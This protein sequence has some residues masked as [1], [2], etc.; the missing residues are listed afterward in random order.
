MGSEKAFRRTGRRHDLIA[1]GIADPREEELPAVGLLEVED[2]ETGRH[3]LLDTLSRQ[4]RQAFAAAAR[5][6]RQ[7]LQQLARSARVDLIE[8][9]TDGGH[10]DALIRFFRMR[11]RRLRRR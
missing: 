3:L 1:V 8:V 10:L 9:A 4:V 7:T 5:Q 2:A 11:E 6:R